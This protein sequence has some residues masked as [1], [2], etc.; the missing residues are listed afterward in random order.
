LE[1]WGYW[2]K[3][4]NFKPA[5][6]SIEAAKDRFEQKLGRLNEEFGASATLPWE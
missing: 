2:M 1:T 5:K 4:R 3:G 6:I